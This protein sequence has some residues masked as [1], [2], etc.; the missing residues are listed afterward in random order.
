MDLTGA[1]TAIGEAT[2]HIA[3]IGVPVL[4]VIAGVFAFRIA[5]RLIS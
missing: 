4:V 5:R 2:G 1:V 3:T